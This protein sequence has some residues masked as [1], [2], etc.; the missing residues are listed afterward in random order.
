[1]ANEI[2]AMFFEVMGSPVKRYSPAVIINPSK[3]FI[4]VVLP[5]PFSPNKPT[6][7]LSERINNLRQRRFA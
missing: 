1:M 4:R 3:H 2:L 5:A 6:I 7:R